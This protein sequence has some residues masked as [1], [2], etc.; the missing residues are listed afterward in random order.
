MAVS[1]RRWGSSVVSIVTRAWTQHMLGDSE[2][3]SASV[4][5]ALEIDPG[6]P[7]TYYYDALLKYRTGD[8]DAALGSLEKRSLVQRQRP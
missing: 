4:A 5:R 7:Y 2:A 3:A 8:V 1:H 6:D